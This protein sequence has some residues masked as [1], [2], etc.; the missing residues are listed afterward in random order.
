[1]MPFTAMFFKTQGCQF[2]GRPFVSRMTSE[3]QL[4][5]PGL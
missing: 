2:G 1:L 5:L 4:A 3:R